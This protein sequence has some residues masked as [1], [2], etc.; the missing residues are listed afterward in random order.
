MKAKKHFGQHFLTNKDTAQR[1]VDALG[2]ISQQDVLEIGPGM[3]VIS[4]FMLHT[5][6]RFRAVEIDPE[7][8][9]YLEAEFASIELIKAD[10]LKVDLRKYYTTSFSIIGNFPYNI[11]SQIVFKIIEN[12]DLVNRWVGMFQL[13]MG[14]RLLATPK[15]KKTYGILSVLL[16][17]YYKIERVMTLP[18][19]AFNPPPKVNSIVLKAEKVDYTM[20][21]NPILLKQI[22]KTSFGQRRK[23]LS[24]SLATIIDKETFNQHQFSTLRPENLTHLQFEELCLFIESNVNR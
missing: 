18:P 10:F 8:A 9:S 15:D 11:S 14:E 16:P 13:E 23:T 3:G 1:I 22:V 20:R 17:F 12:S 6:K 2:D 19:G 24:N 7:A 21:C 4:Q 5:A